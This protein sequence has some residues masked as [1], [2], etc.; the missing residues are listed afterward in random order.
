MSL[1]ARE[2][3]NGNSP[4][5]LNKM[6]NNFMTIWKTLFGGL[7]F[8]DTNSNLKKRIQTQTMPIQGEGNFDKNFPLYIRF[9]VPKNVKS[10]TTSSLN[11]ICERYRMDSGIAM[12]GGAIINAPIEM[13]LA[14]SNQ[15]TASVSSPT[16]GVSSVSS[17]TVGVTS[18]SAGKYSRN[19]TT[20]VKE[21]YRYTTGGYKDIEQPS[22]RPIWGNMSGDGSTS[23]TATDYITGTSY[24]GYGLLGV[25]QRYANSNYGKVNYVDLCYFNHEHE[26]NVSIPE[27][28]HTMEIKP[29]THEITMKPHSH[30]ITMKPHTHE[31]TAKL[32]IPAHTHSLK[33]GI[34]ISTQSADGV[35]VSLNGNVI[36]SMDSDANSVKNDIDVTD[37]INIGAWN[38][39]ECKTNTLARVTL[40]GIIELI[41]DY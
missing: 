1:N 13:S 34:Q 8:S 11:L 19:I 5:D 21:W 24:D 30:E 35:S 2:S 4:Q 12:D 28:S 15:G 32:D 17:K 39:I 27:H 23:L 7:D 14:S 18:L 37:K 3:I 36:T 31:A 38:V 10:I 22:S 20:P 29:H 33:E 41:M 9:Y 16:V 25:V 26:V 6:N 40:Y